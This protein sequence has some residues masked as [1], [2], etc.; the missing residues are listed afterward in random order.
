MPVH[1]ENALGAQHAAACRGHQAHRAGA[2]D[3][4]CR[5]LL[6]PGID[7]GLVAGRQ[8]VGQEQHLLVV[9]CIGH[10]QRPDIGLGHAHVLGLPAGQTAIQMAEAEQR[11]RWAHVLV[12]EC[13]ALAGIGGLASGELLQHAVEAASAGHHERD[14]HTVA[15]FDRGDIGADVFDDAHELMAE[16]IAMPQVRNLAAVQMQVRAADGGGGDAQDKIVAFDKGRIRHGFDPH[17]A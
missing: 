7:D 17:I 11:R 1:H 2:E 9:Q 14:H 8:D 12:V 5:A 6:D 4:H 10:H 15:G 16:N 13:G 3:R